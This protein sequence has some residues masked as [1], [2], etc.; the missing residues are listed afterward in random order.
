MASPRDGGGEPYPRAHRR[1]QREPVA[2]P[3][4]EK[5]PPAITVQ[6]DG[7]SEPTS[8]FAAVTEPGP[9]ESERGRGK[10]GQPR[11]ARRRR[12][13]Y[14]ARRGRIGSELSAGEW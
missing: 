9:L 6:A 11:R 10:D 12:G 8:R 7:G 13:L 4:R 5:A 2:R 14:A 1:W 3:W